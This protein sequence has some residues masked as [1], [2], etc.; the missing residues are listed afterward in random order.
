MRLGNALFAP[1][2]A[3]IA[4]FGPEVRDGTL[5]VTLAE[6]LRQMFLGFALAFAV[7]VP[8][9]ILMARSRLVDAV[10]HPWLSMAVVTSVAALVPLFNLIFGTGFWFRVWIVYV[11]AI[12]FIMLTV[13]QGARGIEPRWLDVGRSFGARPFQSFWK[14]MLPA[15]FPYIFAGARIGLIHAIRA[16]VVAEMF[17]VVGFGA[18]IHNAGLSISTA[19]LL[20]LLFILMLLGIAANWGLRE[21]VSRV[22]LPPWYEER[23]KA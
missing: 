14:I 21:R 19:P 2:T 10:V 12:W 20:G 8:V 6:S 23:M 4:E 1:P 7:G 3:V 17:V 16:M 9:G 18:L 13:Y 11:T 22:A 15:L 5:F